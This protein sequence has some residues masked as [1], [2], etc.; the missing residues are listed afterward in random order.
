MDALAGMLTE[1]IAAHQKAGENGNGNGVPVDEIVED[2]AED[3]D[4]PP[5]F[6]T[7][8]E[9][10]PAGLDEDVE[11]EVVGSMSRRP[12][13]S[14]PGAGTASA[15]PRRPARRSPPPASSRPPGPRAS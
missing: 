3:E 4:E 13:I 15:I 1:L 2:D 10:D 11:D 7:E 9:G 5:T 14:A 12:R 8:G 6:D